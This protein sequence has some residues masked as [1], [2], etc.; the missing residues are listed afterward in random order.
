MF[1]SIME[2]LWNKRFLYRSFNW[3]F[4]YYFPRVLSDMWN[5]MY[6]FDTEGYGS[7]NKSFL[8]GISKLSPA[9]R[10]FMCVYKSLLCFSWLKPG[11]VQFSQNIHKTFGYI[12]LQIT[13][14]FGSS[15]D[16]SCVEIVLEK[17]WTK[18]LFFI[19]FIFTDTFS[20]FLIFGS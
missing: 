17:W 7:T 3:R 18:V 8:L 15:L 20:M 4:F 14:T 6:S 2:R 1:M 16:E 5:F 19:S 9:Y 10:L 11:Q 13:C 12:V